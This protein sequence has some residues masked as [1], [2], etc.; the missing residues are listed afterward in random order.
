MKHTR[1]SWAIEHHKEDEPGSWLI[2][3][4]LRIVDELS[5]NRDTVAT[6][7]MTGDETF[8][9]EA[10]LPNARLI[11]AAPELMDACRKLA[12]LGDWTGPVPKGFNEAWRAALHAI[13]K[14]KGEPS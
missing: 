9:A 7:A 8:D 6:V 3:N 12:R 10:T 1:R 11:A 2:L 5:D 13:A 14:A 4:E